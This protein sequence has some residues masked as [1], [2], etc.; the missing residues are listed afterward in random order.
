MGPL[1][2]L[3]TTLCHPKL[4]LV[5]L[6]LALMLGGLFWLPA[7]LPVAMLAVV[8]SCAFHGH[9]PWWVIT[10]DD[11]VSP[12]GSYEPT[13]RKV[14]AT[15]GRFV[16]DVYWLAFRNVLFG[17]SYSFKPTALFPV[18]DRYEHLKRAWKKTK[19]GTRFEAA[20][21]VMRRFELSKLWVLVGWKVD[22]IVLDP[23][24]KRALL[25]MEGRPIF[26]FRLSSNA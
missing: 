13:V 8:V 23:S 26:S 5:T 18:N 2:G 16:G 17:L 24:T 25:N 1:I 3:F 15:F 6:P 14:Y 20:G 11:P 9:Y 22:S 19:Y 21:Y 10:P 4:S 7:L 12:F